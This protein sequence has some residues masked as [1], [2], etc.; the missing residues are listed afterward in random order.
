VSGARLIHLNGPPGIGK[1]VLALRYAA[2]H[3]G[4]LVCDIDRLRTMVAGWEHDFAGAGERIR[5]TAI[6]A[7]S[8]YLATGADV[9]LPQLVTR[10]DQLDR[11]R[12]AAEAAGAAYVGVVLAADPDEVVARFRRRA[13]ALDDPV[14]RTVTAVVDELGGD[15][16]LRQSC[17]DLDRL[18][19]TEA[20]TTVASTD[21]ESTYAAL[22]AVLG[23]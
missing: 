12:V 20:L 1:S 6:A 19:R 2:D 22:L 3:P 14:T 4:V 11:F 21:P 23:T 8:A 7:I 15:A 13:D 18:A 16:A 17:R 10:P 5:T 9:V